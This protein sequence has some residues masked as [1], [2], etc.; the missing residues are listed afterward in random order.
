MKVAASILGATLGRIFNV[1]GE[2]I[3][4]LGPVDTR[5]TSPI[6]RSA[7]G[8]VEQ[9]RHEVPYL[10]WIS[11]VPPKRMSDPFPCGSWPYHSVP[12]GLERIL[13]HPQVSVL[14]LQ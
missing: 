2:P 1:L 8:G 4:N 6:H 13:E 10:S 5:T 9:P 12:D 11:L 7:R 3:D 14:F